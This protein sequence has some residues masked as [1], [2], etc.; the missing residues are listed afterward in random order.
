MTRN[1]Y[2]LKTSL[3]P[4]RDHAF[5]CDLM[6][7][8]VAVRKQIVEMGHHSRIRLHYGALMGMVE[9]VTLLYFHWLNV[10]PKDP[11]WPERDR[12]VLSKGHGVP[13][14]YAVLAEKGFFPESELA[15]ACEFNSRLGG[16]PKYGLPGVEAATGSLGHGLSI[17]VGMAVAARID[18]RPHRVFVLLGDGECQE[19]TIWEAALSAHKHQLDNLTILVDRNQFQCYG[20]TAEV[21]DL[22]PFADKW[23]SFG[24]AVRECDGHDPSELAAHLNQVPFEP[25]KTGVLIC[26]TRKGMGLATTVDN[27]DW[28]HKSRLK[29]EEM[30]ALFRDLENAL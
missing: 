21:Q 18:R 8:A 23:R 4:E 16:H 30:A 15:T 13:S 12:F 10:H 17:G 22:E 3:T 27:P 29:D 2:P 1:A 7:K 11:N 28:H 20:P 14:L 6:L 24:L 9:M 25:G 5:V 26:H 19:G